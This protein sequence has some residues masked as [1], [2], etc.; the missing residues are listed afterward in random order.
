MSNI[1]LVASAGMKNAFRMKTGMIILISVTLICVIGVALLMCLLLIAPEMASAAPDR[2]ALE[3]YLNLILYS[4]SLISIGVTLNSLVFQ[5]MVRE[6]TRGNL[7]ALMATPLNLSDI[8]LGKSFSLFVP[9]LV[10][11][12]VLTLLNLVIINLIYFLPDT[13]FILNWQM[14]VNSLV[15]L[16][17]MYLAFGLLVHLI[18]LTTKPATGNVIAQ[19]FLPVIANLMIQLTVR[20]VISANSWQ[21]MVMNLG[22]AVILGGI[23]LAVR[24]RLTPDRVIISAG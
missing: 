23:I 10:L 21:F 18:G 13:G 19:V 3:R 11:A 24:S 12:I 17:V 14:L 5:T 8:W 15:I 7:A 6:K 22:I 4:S 1:R 9:G 16:P 20:N 2:E